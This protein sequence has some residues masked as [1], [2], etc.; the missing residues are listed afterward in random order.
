M[1]VL[2]WI[3]IGA[4]VLLGGWAYFYFK[5]KWFTPVSVLFMKKETST[6]GREVCHYI[7]PQNIKSE[8]LY[9]LYLGKKILF[10]ERISKDKCFLRLPYYRKTHLA[11]CN[12]EK[13]V[14]ADICPV[15]SRMLIFDITSLPD[16]LISTGNSNVHTNTDPSDQNG[17]NR[18]DTNPENVEKGKQS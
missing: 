9:F 2:G 5:K 3:A 15:Q 11:L 6:D 1:N 8:N 10:S 14:L 16:I 4:L 12:E 13:A 18:S 7:S 17:L